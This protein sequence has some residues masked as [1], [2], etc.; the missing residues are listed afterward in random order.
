MSML[1]VALLRLMLWFHTSPGFGTLAWDGDSR[2]EAPMLGKGASSKAKTKPPPHPQHWSFTPGGRHGGLRPQ[3][4]ARR[5]IDISR[6]LHQ[7]NC[8]CARHY[9]QQKRKIIAFYT[10]KSSEA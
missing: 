9:L 6:L 7:K 3:N 8:F 5:R 2:D 10:P 4:P 1:S